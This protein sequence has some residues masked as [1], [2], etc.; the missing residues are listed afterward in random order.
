MVVISSTR[1]STSEPLADII[2]HVSELVTNTSSETGVLLTSDYILANLTNM[3]AIICFLVQWLSQ[4][5]TSVDDIGEA[6]D[7]LL[8]IKACLEEG[9]D[10]GVPRHSDLQGRHEK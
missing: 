3:I 7:S 8:N 9:N 1:T 4:F 2:E 6:A 5:C 10:M